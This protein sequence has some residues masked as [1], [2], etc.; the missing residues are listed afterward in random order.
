MKNLMVHVSKTSVVIPT[1]INNV[2]FSIRNKDFRVI[3]YPK[4]YIVN[5]CQ[6]INSFHPVFLFDPP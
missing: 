4:F 3:S 6:C 2:V 1:L 5:V